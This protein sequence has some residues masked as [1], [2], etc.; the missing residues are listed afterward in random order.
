MSDPSG[1]QIDEY[2]GDEP[3]GSTRRR[4][5]LGIQFECCRAYQRIYKNAEGTEY[6][7]FCPQC[8][9]S[10]RVPIGSGGTDARFFSAR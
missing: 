5:W 2:A 1:H 9:V 6:V 8:G 3:Q 7:G 10:V 4:P